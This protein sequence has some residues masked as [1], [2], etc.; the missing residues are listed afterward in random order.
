MA[1][2]DYII[3]NEFV[4]GKEP[5]KKN[6]IKINGSNGW[7]NNGR[8]SPTYGCYRFSHG[9]NR[10]WSYERFKVGIRLTD[11][12][13]PCII[14]NADDGPSKMTRQ[15]QSELRA[16]VNEAKIRHAYLPFSTLASAGISPEGIQIVHITNDKNLSTIKKDKNGNE[17]TSNTHF[18]GE[19]LFRHS[20]FGNKSIYYVSGLDRN[21]NPSKRNFYLARLIGRKFKTVDEALDSLR[22]KNVPKDSLR[23]GEYFFVPVNINVKKDLVCSSYTLFEN[24][25]KGIP[26]ISDDG[27]ILSTELYGSFMYNALSRR[28]GRHVATRIFIDKKNVYASGMVRDIKH[29]ALKLGD[30]KQWFKVVRNTADGSWGATGEVD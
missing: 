27:E 17:Y 16:A 3:A 20:Y 21:D 12:V 4:A 13:G 22:P 14:I 29:S 25:N 10:L 30:G 8:L 23:Q 5:N 11:K 19:T 6:F 9:G 2:R 18:L 15:H 24:V 28:K 1:Q 26:I 7:N